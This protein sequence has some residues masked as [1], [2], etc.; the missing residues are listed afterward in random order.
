MENRYAIKITSEFLET[1]YCRAKQ[2]AITKWRKE[3][4]RVIIDSNGTLTA[5]F[6]GYERGD[7]DHETIR[8][9]DLTSDLDAIAKE[10][11]EKLEQERIKREAYNKEQERL[12]SIREKEQRRQQYAKLKKEFE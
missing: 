5:I 8:V 9:E 6:D 7:E 1:L 3:P 2:F 11:A 10:R 12:Q 4:D